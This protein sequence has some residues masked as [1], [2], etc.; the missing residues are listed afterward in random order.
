MIRIGAVGAENSHTVAIAKVINIQEL[1]RGCRV[2]CVWGETAR[3]A[4]DASERGQIPEIV[5]TPEDM[6]GK[7]DAAFVD[8]RHAKYHLPAARPLLEAR[9]PLF[10]DKPFCYRVREG[11]AFLK[12]AAELGVPVCSYSTLPKQAS[13]MQL[14]KDVRKL[15]RIISV[16]STRAS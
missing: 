5:K 14:R 1:V 11:R 15:G 13:F 9:I 16:V 7:V 6:I 12:R 4:R 10:I 8:H 3:F 2:S